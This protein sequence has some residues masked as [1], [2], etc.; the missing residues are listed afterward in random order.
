M[1]SPTRERVLAEVVWPVCML[2]VCCLHGE[3]HRDSGNDSGSDS[4]GEELA[5][6]M[7]APRT[8]WVAQYL[9]RESSWVT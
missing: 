7:I 6:R 3:R 5:A 8:T 1:V 2:F 4:D 9:C